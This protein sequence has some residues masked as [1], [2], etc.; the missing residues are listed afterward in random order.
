MKHVTKAIYKKKAFTIG[1]HGSRG[2]EPMA[3]MEGNM[4]TERQAW[5]WRSS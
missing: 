2:L 1:A 3:V 4:A 5:L